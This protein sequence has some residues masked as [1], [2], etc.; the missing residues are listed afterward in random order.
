VYPQVGLPQHEICHLNRFPLREG[1]PFR[2]LSVGRFLHWKG[3]E[4][5]L[6]AFARFHGE[7]PASEYWFIG[8]GPE[9]DRLEDVAE[10]LNVAEAVRFWGR[11]GRSETFEK[12]AECDVLL[13][14]SLHDSYPWVCIEA[15][16]AG[17]PVIC[18]D[19]GGPALQV[20]DE[21][22]IKVPATAP[23]QAIADLAA[24]LAR[25][26]KDPGLRQRISQAAR[27]RAREYFDWNK[28]GDRLMAVYEAHFQPSRSI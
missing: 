19:V 25:V 16:A 23:E 22:G 8:A 24:A 7:F 18:L 12:L 4:I 28:L 6:R 15:M 9:R 1:N 10:K 5:G 20:S 13:H 3:F 2:V 11:M 17:R 21:T 14:P 27:I 26:A